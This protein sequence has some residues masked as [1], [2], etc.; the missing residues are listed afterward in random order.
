MND[1]IDAGAGRRPR[2]VLR[3]GLLAATTLGLLAVGLLPGVAEASSATSLATRVTATANVRS[4][5]SVASAAS[6][7]VCPLP[8]AVAG[9]DKRD[10]LRPS[11]PQPGHLA[12]STKRISIISAIDRA[13][14]LPAISPRRPGT[15][16]GECSLPPKE[17]RVHSAGSY[18]SLVTTNRENKMIDMVRMA[19]HRNYVS[20]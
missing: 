17:A 15:N 18:K 5:P 19:P 13:L 11:E 20:Q 9:R 7:Y 14:Y 8:T 6:G 4:S 12:R 16:D 10:L 2:S 1:D 3:R